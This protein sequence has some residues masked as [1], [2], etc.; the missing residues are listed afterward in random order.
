MDFDINNACHHTNI[1][2]RKLIVY[3]IKLSA[4]VNP[5]YLRF[6]KL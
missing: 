6:I 4:V 3:V 5:K 2:S 1:E